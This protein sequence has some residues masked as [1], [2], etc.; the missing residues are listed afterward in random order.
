MLT[1]ESLE[2]FARTAFKPPPKQTLSQ[3][4]DAN[5]YLSAESSAEAGRWHTIPYQRGI[6]DAMT[7]PLIEQV[8]V[9]KSARVGYT[10][11]L[12][13]LIG[14]HVDYDPCPIMVVLPTIED[15]ESHSKEEIAPMLRDTP[16]LRGKV[17]DAKARDS[18]NTITSKLFPGGSLS[19]VG[20]NSPR[21]FRRVSRRV[22]VFDEVD[23]YPPSAGA[24]GD[25]IKLGIKRTEYYWNRKIVAGSTPT[26][27]EIS[28]IQKLYLQSDQRRYYVPCPH[29][30]AAQYLK[31]GGVDKKFGIKWPDGEP[32]KAY[33]VCE[34]NGCIIEHK[35]KKWMIEEADRLSIENPFGP[36]GWKATAPG[37]GKHAGFHIWAAY[38]YSPN[39]TWGDLAAEF[40]ES[41]D[42]PKTLQTFVNTA[43][44]ECWT[45][46]YTAK[47]GAE[48]LELRAE[49][50]NLLTV[51]MAG[52]LL[53]AGVDVQDNRLAMVV[54]A[55]GEGEESWLVNWME[56]YGDPSDLGPDGPW[57]QV[58]SVLQQY[59][60]HAS[61]AKL[62]I[63]ACAVDTGGHYTHEA[64]MFCRARKKR[65]VIAV[66]GSSNSNAPALGKPS[67]Q[68]VNFKNQTIKAGVELWILG[69][70]AI[71]GT[72]YGRLKKDGERS[73]P[74]GPGSIHFPIGLNREYFKQLTAEKQTF[75]YINGFK[76][77]Y[78]VKK[79][80]DRNE[81]LDCEVYSY[82]ALQYL[83]TR[84]N[85]SQIWLRAKAILDTLKPTAA[86]DS[87]PDIQT[88]ENKQE[89]PAVSASRKQA[90][91]QRRKSGFVNNWKGRK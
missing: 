65:H 39:A 29:C 2:A 59:Y 60:V 57:A 10:K 67:R 55:Y 68:D 7:D 49:E 3:W 33:Y 25:Q 90:Q 13:H 86:S 46:D 85:R 82:A 14:Y 9:M 58:D 18:G 48:A 28:R 40:L 54:K 80:G 31:W 52:L 91:P 66:K 51:P 34:A 38:S 22:V 17:A 72:I 19:L 42:D 71:K 56:I 24:E 76:R 81:A 78:W 5:A 69:V 75:R 77:I 30:G 11:C 20:A 89:L 21:G 35:D 16:V 44:G 62:R 64:Y 6:M 53:V 70:D 45:A 4:A 15:A 83:Y 23:G 1:I 88:E 41:K 27:D 8:T 63:R 32:R 37:N 36:Y 61:G 84:V 47:L 50:Y 73:I 74:G 79:D 43:L 26:I 12:N 87:K